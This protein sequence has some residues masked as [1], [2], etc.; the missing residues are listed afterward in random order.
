MIEQVLGG[1]CGVHFHRISIGLLAFLEIATSVTRDR[2]VPV[3]CLIVPAVTL[4]NIVWGAYWWAQPI[5]NP[6][7]G[8]PDCWQQFV[9]FALFAASI[10]AGVIALV[11]YRRRFLFVAAIVAN[12]LWVAI[13]S[14]LVALMGTIHQWI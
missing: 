12:S 1:I 3:V 5:Q 10:I 2:K 7:R 13:L 6:G 4:L 8:C 14:S 11:M 9:V